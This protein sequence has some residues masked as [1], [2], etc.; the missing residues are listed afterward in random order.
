MAVVERTATID[1]TPNDLW[2]ILADFASISH[3]APNVDHSCIMT[4]QSQDVGAVRRIQT[5]GAT[6]LETV[7]SWDPSKQL[8]Y[9]ITGL[10][11]VIKQ[12]TNTWRLMPTGS[13]TRVTLTSDIDAGPRPP[14]QMVAK[15]AGRKL[16]QASDQMLAGLAAAA[17]QSSVADD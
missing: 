11:P 15:M 5:G 1:A 9:T 14:Q 4:D 13:Q 3:W 6:V 16:G 8:T 10:P 12:V 2:A 7:T 17:K